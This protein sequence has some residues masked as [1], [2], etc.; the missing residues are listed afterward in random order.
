[1]SRPT[2]STEL[3]I[4][5]EEDKL[6]AEYFFNFLKPSLIASLLGINVFVSTLNSSILTIPHKLSPFW[7]S[8]VLQT[9]YPIVKVKSNENQE[10]QI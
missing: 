1:M 9:T 6:W 2:N 8:S 10:L 5:V 7:F 3:I 4:F